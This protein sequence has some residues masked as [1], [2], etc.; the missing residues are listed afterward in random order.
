MIPPWLYQESSRMMLLALAHS[1]DSIS[2][3]L[4]VQAQKNNRSKS[5][6]QSDLLK[7][8]RRRG[9]KPSSLSP[10]EKRRRRLERGRLAAN[11]CRRKKRELENDLETRA[12]ELLQDRNE[13]LAQNNELRE[14]LQNLVQVAMDHGD[15]GCGG[16]PQLANLLKW[17]PTSVESPAMAPQSL[18][19]YD[20]PAQGYYPVNGSPGAFG[21]PA[22]KVEYPGDMVDILYSRSGQL[23]TF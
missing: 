22:P 19:E 4:I 3:M 18:A 6:T 11:K 14:E 9:R 21:A 12:K 10:E 2:A 1:I 23:V 20:A 17:F 8:R 16:F 5:A 13:M 7:P 15:P